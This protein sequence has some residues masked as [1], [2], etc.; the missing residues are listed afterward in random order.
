MRAWIIGR[1][2]KISGKDLVDCVDN[3]DGFEEK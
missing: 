1:Y 3:M 2:E